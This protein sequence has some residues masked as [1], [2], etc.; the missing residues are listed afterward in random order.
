VRIPSFLVWL[1]LVLAGC[2][3]GGDDTDD[4]DDDP[5]PRCDGRLQEE[6]G[7]VDAPFDADG[8]GFFDIDNADCASTWPADQLDCDDSD[9]AINPAAIELP[10]NGVD[11]DCRVES[12]DNRDADGDGV[13]VCDNDCNDNDDDIYPGAEETCFDDIDNDCDTIV[14]NDC[15]EDYSGFWSVE[16]SDIDIQCN[17]LGAPIIDMEFTELNITYIIPPNMTISSNTSPQPPALNIEVGPDGVVSYQG[18][19]GGDCRGTYAIEAVFTDANTLEGTFSYQFQPIVPGVC[20]GC[21][22]PETIT[23]FTATRIPTP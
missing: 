15:G 7:T 21:A 2:D 14:D 9:P 8:D 23:E 19:D 1:P 17:A 4:L 6:E 13:G 20:L 3:A 5:T 22:R 12:Q 11:D 18:N 16:P 10:C